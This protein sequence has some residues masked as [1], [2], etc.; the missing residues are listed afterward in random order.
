[1]NPSIWIAA[2]VAMAVLDFAWALYTDAVAKSKPLI[3]SAWA[4]VI[5]ALGGVTTL[6]IMHDP[7]YLSA[8]LIGAFGGTY[9]A[10]HWSATKDKQ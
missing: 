9:A 1:M 8:T 4:T 5:A 6:A 2:C 10:T 7:L 3:A